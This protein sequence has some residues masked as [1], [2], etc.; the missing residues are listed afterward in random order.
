MV[1]VSQP[2]YKNNYF[3]QEDGVHTFGDFL[4][5]LPPSLHNFG[6]CYLLMPSIVRMECDCVSGVVTD[7]L[8]FIKPEV[9]IKPS[10]CNPRFLTDEVNVKAYRAAYVL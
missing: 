3:M 2:W 7:D 10:S 9:K 8:P 6:H 4:L 5:V 1:T